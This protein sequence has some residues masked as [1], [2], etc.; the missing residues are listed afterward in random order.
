LEPRGVAPHIKFRPDLP[1]R[2]I[3]DGFD[4][5]RSKGAN[6]IAV[7][8]ECWSILGRDARRPLHLVALAIALVSTGCTAISD[9]GPS[10]RDVETRASA[11]IGPNLDRS[12][13]EYIV[14]HGLAANRPAAARSRT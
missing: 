7:A 9:S 2:R 6:V 4:P 8:Q 1:R 5:S 12:L 14:P 11:T 10:R 3:G 13:L